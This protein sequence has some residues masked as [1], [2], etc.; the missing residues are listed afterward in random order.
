MGSLVDSEV[1]E[2]LR[3]WWMPCL[4]PSACLCGSGRTTSSNIRRFLSW[5]EKRKTY[6]YSRIVRPKS[7]DEV[8]F[9][10]NNDCVSHHR[11]AG[12]SVL[13]LVPHPDATCY[14]LRFGGL[15]DSV[16]KR[17]CVIGGLPGTGAREDA[18]G[19]AM[20]VDSPCRFV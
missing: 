5:K 6:P 19:V 18:S 13:V 17:Q 11:N 20:A 1:F 4:Q 10:R 9:C 7:K 15:V 14:D 12:K 16:S 8:A 2:V 3:S